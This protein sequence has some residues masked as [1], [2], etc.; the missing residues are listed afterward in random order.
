MTV[1]ELKK[2]GWIVFE[3]ISGSKAY[4]TD[5]PGSDTDIKGVYILPK[6]RLYGLDYLPQINN[7][8]NDETYYEIGRF[9][10]LLEKNNPNI[11]ELLA[12]P[13]DKILYKH[14]IFDRIDPQIFISKKCKDTFAGYAFSQ[15][16]KARGLNKKIAN[17]VEKTKKTILEFCHILQGQGSIS[18]VKW[19]K[20]NDIEQQ[21]CGLV[22]VPHFKD[23]YGIY[24]DPKNELGYKG[25]LRKENATSVLLSSVKK[26]EK[27]LAWLHFNQ[28]GYTKYCKD[29][30]DYWDWVENRNELRYQTNIEHGKNYDSKNMMHTFR[31]LDMA[32][33][34]LGAGQINVRRPNREELLSIRRGEWQYDDLISMAENKMAEVEK[35]AAESPL[36]EEPD[37][38]MVN[39]LLITLRATYYGDQVTPYTTVH[40][41]L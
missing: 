18:L 24:P 2:T 23:I 11:L 9:F 40:D 28:D 17:P 38:D 41:L 3:C 29:Y 10:E 36:P 33:E 13:P 5:L 32:V 8:T 14:P 37:H 21:N 30:H 27:P 6:A 15:I 25:I 16:K 34:L 31:L 39:K 12:S 20:A 1:E 22:K 7:E 4:G 35:A 19:L 26:G